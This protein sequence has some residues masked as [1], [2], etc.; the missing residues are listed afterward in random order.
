MAESVLTI[1]NA[2]RSFGMT[3]AVAD[4]SLS[5]SR[6]EIYGLLGPDGAGKTTT[7]R[8][9][10]GALDPDHGQIHVMGLDVR[11]EPDRAR[12]SIGYMPQAYGLYGDLTVSENLRF[13]GRL[14]GVASALLERR[15]QEL[16]TFVHLEEFPDR[17]AG[18]LSGGMYKKL[19]IACSILHE[20]R[21]LILDE[22]TNGVDPVSRRDL[23]ALLFSLVRDGVSVIVSTPYMDEAERCHRVGV[24]VQGRI[25][26]EGVPQDILR[27]LEGRLFLIRCER[28]AAALNRAKDILS[29]AY[30]SSSPD[31]LR[32]LLRSA[33]ERSLLVKTSRE[34]GLGDPDP[35][36]PGMEDLL[37]DLSNDLSLEGG[38]SSPRSIHE[39]R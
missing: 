4:I 3:R 7:L 37:I 20:P 36:R 13:F 10:A 34:L 17:R 22:P 2:A 21:V 24:L 12:E 33:T 23:W 18:D 9:L 28:P 31:G 15:I 39:G 11:K 16:L 25:A 6:G 29:F 27:R 26:L 5:L 38:E 35:V 30:L 8:M 32:V 1:Q 19:A 14:F